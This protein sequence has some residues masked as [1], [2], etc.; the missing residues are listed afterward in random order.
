MNGLPALAEATAGKFVNGLPAV[1]SA[2]K[3]VNGLPA[4]A[5]ASAGKAE[6]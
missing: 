3:F 4:V 2:G 6:R 5:E 1:A